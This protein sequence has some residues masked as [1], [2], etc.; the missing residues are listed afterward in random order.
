MM[1]MM[2]MM[3]IAMIMFMADKT[4]SYHF[5]IMMMIMMMMM[6]MMMADKTFPVTR[7]SRKLEGDRTRIHSGAPH[8]G[9]LFPHNHNGHCSQVFS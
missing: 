7:R 1:M 2:T 8:A 6:M 5:M 9:N 3:T 4:F